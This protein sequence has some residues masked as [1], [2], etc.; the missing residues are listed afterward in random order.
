M[1][2]TQIHQL[3]SY[4]IYYV[5]H[6][7]S[8]HTY[9][10][11]LFL[12]EGELIYNVVPTSAIQQVIHIYTFFFQ[13]TFPLWFIPGDWIQVSVLYGRILFIH[14]KCNSSHQPNPKSQSLLVHSSPSP[15]LWQP[16]VVFS[17]CLFLL[18][19]MLK[20]LQARLQQ[21]HEP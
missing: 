1:P 2:F 12:I 11:I 20:I 21:I 18:F 16:Q 19:L 5:F 9:S 6:H 4:P 10:F 14:S 7:F 3:W 8:S 17:V 13:Y 15:T